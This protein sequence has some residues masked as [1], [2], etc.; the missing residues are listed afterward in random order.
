MEGRTPILPFSVEN[1]ITRTQSH[2]HLQRDLFA[3]DL[4]P[5]RTN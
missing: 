2:L 5:S 4:P 3:I 1:V